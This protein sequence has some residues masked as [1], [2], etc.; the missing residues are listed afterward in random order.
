MKKII[1]LVFAVFVIVCVFPK[2]SL[3]ADDTENLVLGN[4]VLT[5]QWLSFH[6]GVGKASIYKKGGKIFIDGYQKE[7]YQGHLNLMSIQGTIRIISRSE[8]EFEGKI[9][10]KIHDINSGV[11]YE[12]NGKFLLKAR[13]SRKYWRMQNM[14]QPDGNFMI[15]DYIDIYFEK[16]R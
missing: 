16:Y 5:L 7:N 13:G 10:T 15:T 6:K 9:I 3:S 1:T 2:N 14:E 11:P 8:L 12:R 4:H